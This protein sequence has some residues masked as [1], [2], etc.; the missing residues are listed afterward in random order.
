MCFISVCI[1]KLITKYSLVQYI[2]L[3]PKGSWE[4][5]LARNCS[6]EFIFKSFKVIIFLQ[7]FTGKLCEL[8]T[9]V[10]VLW[11]CIRSKVVFSVWQL[12]VFFQCLWCWFTWTLNFSELSQIAPQ[13]KIYQEA[14]SELI[15]PKYLSWMQLKLMNSYTHKFLCRTLCFLCSI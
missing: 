8:F 15:F 2:F 9:R 3:S 1:F 4:K 14:A 5:K 13:S 10:K 11:N 12:L 7:L 6:N